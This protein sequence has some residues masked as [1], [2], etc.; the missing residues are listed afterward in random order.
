MSV[1]FCTS[2]AYINNWK[3]R[4]SKVISIYLEV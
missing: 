2:M 3:W 1:H 4:Y